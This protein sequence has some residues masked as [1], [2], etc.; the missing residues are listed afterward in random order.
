MAQIP[1]STCSVATI[2]N[3]LDRPISSA[4]DPIAAA[5]ISPAMI[6]AIPASSSGRSDPE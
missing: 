1:A 4:C 5:W 2:V 6:E 3:A